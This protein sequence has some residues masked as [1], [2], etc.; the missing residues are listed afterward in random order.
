LIVNG[1][2]ATQAGGCVTVMSRSTGDGG[3]EIRISDT[4]KG[5]SPDQLDQIFKPFFTTRHQGTGLG[6][7]ITQ[8]IIERH[9]GTLSVESQVGIGTTFRVV[10]PAGGVDGE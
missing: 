3:A 5:I 7:S 2:Q 4:G 8:G 10:L 9:G 6:L 1:V